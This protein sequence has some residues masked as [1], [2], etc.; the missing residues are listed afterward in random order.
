MMFERTR[1]GFAAFLLL[2]NPAL[3]ADLRVGI[4]ADPTIDPQFLYLAPNIAIARHM[5]E[6]LIARDT[7][8]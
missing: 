8:R 7:G 3:A 4:K 6:P 5:F 1:L 2:A